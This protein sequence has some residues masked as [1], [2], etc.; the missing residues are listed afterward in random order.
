MGNVAVEPPKVQPADLETI[1][2][3][4]GAIFTSVDMTE[5]SAIA[6]ELEAKAQRLGELFAQ[7]SGPRGEEVVNLI[8]AETFISR[9]KRRE[10]SAIVTEAILRDALIALAD[11]SQ[12]PMERVSLMRYWLE[13]MGDLANDLPFEL[14]H[15][16]QPDRFCLATSWVW[17]PLTETGAVKLLLDEGFELFGADQDEAFAR[18]NFAI[19]YL[20][21]TA[22]AA[23]FIPAGNTHFAMDA[24]LA[25]VYGVYMSTVLE[26]RMTKEFNKILPPLSQLMRRLLGI[27]HKEVN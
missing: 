7:L 27:Y 6:S 10:I 14:L 18:L 19:D 24:F 13:P 22:Q 8:I 25:G 15:F 3:L 23:G 11:S 4:A 2:D 20:G 16:L 17:N 9:R 26:M 21:Q 12:G 5:M 1:A